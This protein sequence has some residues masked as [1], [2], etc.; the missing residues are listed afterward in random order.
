M[1]SNQVSNATIQTLSTVF[2]LTN[3][4]DVPASYVTPAG[5]RDCRII[6]KGDKNPGKVSQFCTLP[7]VTAGFAQSFINNHKGL[8]LV[9]DFISGLQDKA[10]RKVYLELS[11]SPIQDDLTIS[12]LCE[13]GAL[14]AVNIRLTKESV[15]AW[16]D[17]VKNKIALVI[18]GRMFASEVTG[19]AG[20]ADVAA[21]FWGGVNGER[22]I[23]IAANYLP[24]FVELS[25][26]SPSFNE[27]VKAKIEMVCLEVM[28]GTALEEK[29]LEKLEKSVE[30]SI[31][32]LGL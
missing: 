31:D 28:T 8:E 4:K 3:L 30:K 27:G 23:K 32:D 7:E 21:A 11:R 16:F 17:S 19:F 29:I 26:R 25:S 18:A 5:M 20:N 2:G 15:T 14:D 22:C 9:Q 12:K 13:V 1:E 6:V 24:L 10:V